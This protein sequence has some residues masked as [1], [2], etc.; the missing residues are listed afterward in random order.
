MTTEVLGTLSFLDIPTVAGQPLLLNAGGVPSINS[1]TFAAR[2][3]A[4]NVGVLYVDTTSN[5]LWRDNGTT[6]DLISA[7]T[8]YTGTANEIDV[9][10]SVIGISDDPVIPGNGRIRL[11]VGTSAQR[12]GSPVTGDAR[13]NTTT[14][15]TEEYNGA[16]WSP[17]GRVLQIATGNV[18]AVSGSTQVPFDN[19]PP[20]S[21]EGFEVW[22]TSFTPISATSRIVITQTMT[23]ACATAART[24]TSSIFTGTTN[25]GASSVHVMT[26]ATTTNLP[27]QLSNNVAYVSGSTAPVT[28]SCRV[29]ANGTGTTYVNQTNA[30][31]LGGA[32]V[33]EY[34]IMEIA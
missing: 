8:T 3:A 16:F 21:S 2:P 15:F 11:P 31:T 29:G 13:F 14:G 32:L 18:N 17:M 6:W 7:T 34:I 4:G 26:G 23:V 9:A 33:S 30:A 1:G 10:G 27:F 24:I 12:P 20:T 28:I 5:L 25:R 19:S 22:T